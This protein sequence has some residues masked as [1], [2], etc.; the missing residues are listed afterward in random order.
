MIQ[1]FQ[2]RI[3]GWFELSSPKNVEKEYSIISQELLKKIQAIQVKTNYMVNTTMMGEY[4]SAFKG[5]GME[6]NEV[7]EYIPGDD[8][9]LIDWNVTARMGH[10][11]IKSFQEER[12]QTIM[13]IVDV[14]SSGEFGSVDQL[15]NEAAAEIASIL[16]FSAIKNN[17]KVGIIIFSDQVEHVISPQKGK[18]HIWNVIRA[19]LSFS[20]KGKKTDFNPPLEYLLQAQKRKTVAFLI[21]DFQTKNYEKILNLS[22]QKH[23]L[24]SIIISDPKEMN[25]PS[26]LGLIHLEDAETGETIIVDSHDHELLN[27]YRRMKAKDRDKLKKYLFASGIDTIEISIEHSLTEPIIRFFKMREKRH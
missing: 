4:V 16:A 14:S 17:D 8:V 15:K 18:A 27:L 12:E 11:F 13:L 7:R 25:L 24:I 6:F 5:R 10:P 21:S 19:I 20:P 26:D 1:S 9:R 2:S 3:L 22:N 23:D